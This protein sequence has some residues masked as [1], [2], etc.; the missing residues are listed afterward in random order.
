M[1]QRFLTVFQ[2]FSRYITAV[3]FMASF[4]VAAAMN[5]IDSLID[6]L[7]MEL[8]KQH[9][10]ADSLPV[11]FNLYDLVHFTDRGMVL[12]AIYDTG[13]RAGSDQ[14]MYDAVFLMAA[15]HEADASKRDELLKLADAIKDSDARERIKLYVRVRY[16]A[17]KIRSLSEDK[18]RSQLLK[19]LAKYKDVLK[20]DRYDRMEYLFCLCSY[21]R[22]M[23]DSELLIGY[24]LELQELVE[25]LPED[26]LPL[27]AL[28]YTQ[29]A[30]CFFNNG[31]YEE[32]VD[33]NRKM[34]EVNGRF[35]KRHA[36]QG[37]VY[38]NYDGSTYQCLYNMLM[39]YDVL[40]DEEVESYYKR[41]C[42]MEQSN[43]RLSSNHWL[44][45]E[46][47]IVYLM[48]KKR[49]DEAIPLI[50]DQ[51]D[52]QNTVA[53]YGYFVKSLAKAARETGNKKA[54]LHALQIRN[55]LLRQRLETNSDLGVQEL[56]TIY[57]V[58]RLQKKNTGLTNE[59]HT[60]VVEHRRKLIDWVILGATILVLCIIW[61]LTMYQRSRSLL[62]KLYESHR[63]FLKERNALKAAQKDL[64][65][66]RDQAKGADKVK[67][68]FVNN[69]SKELRDPLAAIVEYSHLIADYASEDRRAYINDYS[70]KLELNTDMLMTLVN[71]VLELPSME[72][73]KLS[74]RISSVYLQE[75]CHF[76]IDLVSKHL[77][78]NVKL[79][80]LNEGEENVAIASDANKI[81][82]ILLHMLLN[83]AKF[84]D[85]GTIKFGYKLAPDRSKITFTVTDTGIGVPRGQEE[86]IFE[87]FHKVDPSTQGN[88]LGLYIGR[89]L[90]S[91]LNGELTL[92]KKYRTGARF[93][94][95]IPLD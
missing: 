52:A 90:A 28:F 15:F 32:A 51:L 95:T 45:N 6:S 20:L 27:R 29:A 59:Q 10:A 75:I 3:V 8:P 54:L 62:K 50:E 30:L 24:L 83:A 85:E 94:L 21:M 49:Y 55:V 40:T 2:V 7:R 22:N 26:E 13:K 77:S 36:D 86:A 23:T 37:R 14:A 84:T 25:T 81:E 46:S 63:K 48:A 69:M 41:L 9:T 79:I 58:D 44:R 31:L 93:I 33:A 65:K 11:L 64:I 39:C 71:D 4:A 80:F 18:R 1:I 53:S 68:D 42:H 73:G 74:V 78:P 87:R 19:T 56:Q 17:N 34:L 70:D 91:L 72:N 82:Q 67:S 5:P 47:R 88:G 60:I 66:A 35:D 61:M 16:S 43:E 38:R 76:T 57:E 92:D 12:D 89:M